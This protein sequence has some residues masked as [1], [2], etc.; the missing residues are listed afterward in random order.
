M[1]KKEDTPEAELD[2]VG[3]RYLKVVNIVFFSDVAIYT[4]ELMVSEHWRPEV[5]EAK[6][7]EISNLL[8]YN[9]FKEVKDV[10]QQTIG[11]K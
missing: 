6:D 11:S 10:G 4:V 1:N 5:K 9:I 2:T 8:D 7:T 3:T